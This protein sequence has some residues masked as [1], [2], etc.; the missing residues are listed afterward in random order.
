M[1]KSNLQVNGVDFKEVDSYD[2][3]QEVNVCHNL[4]PKIARQKTGRG[5]GNS[6]AS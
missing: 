1:L 5:G 2:L 4:Q 6:M 3:G